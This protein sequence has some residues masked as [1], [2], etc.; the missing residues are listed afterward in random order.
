VGDGAQDTS[1]PPVR[2]VAMSRDKQDWDDCIGGAPKLYSEVVSVFRC[3][4]IL[5]HGKQNFNTFIKQI[6]NKV[7]TRETVRRWNQCYI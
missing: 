7:I 1:I 6:G 2:T 4:L 5:Q 3:S